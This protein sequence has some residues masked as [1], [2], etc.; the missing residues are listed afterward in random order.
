LIKLIVFIFVALSLITYKAHA[1]QDDDWILFE[2]I[3]TIDSTNAYSINDFENTPESIVMFFYA[4]KIRND[5]E[6]KQ[7]LPEESERSERL[8]RKL[9]EYENWIFT[10]F[11]LVSKMEYEKNKTWIKIFME[12]EFDSQQDSGTDEVTVEFIDGKWIITSVPT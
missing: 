7:V 6:W 5:D 11:K 3:L 12:I 1:Q 10:K 9:E 8:S 4:S 2:N